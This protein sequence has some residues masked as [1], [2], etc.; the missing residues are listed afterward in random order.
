MFLEICK[1]VL[2]VGAG[3]QKAQQATGKYANPR[4]VNWEIDVSGRLAGKVCEKIQVVVM[5]VRVEER[6]SDVYLK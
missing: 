6:R 3:G 4:V 5:L 1:W 2:C